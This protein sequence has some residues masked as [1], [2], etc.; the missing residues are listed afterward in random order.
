MSNGKIETNR[1]GESAARE[2]SL[3]E[4][5]TV[6]AAKGA[7]RGNTNSGAIFLKIDLKQVVVS[8]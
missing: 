6:S 7:L 1:P 4:L 3:L 2:L 5:E 8:L